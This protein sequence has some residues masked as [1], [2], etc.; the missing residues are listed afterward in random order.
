[1]RKI[2]FN[3]KKS[4]FLKLYLVFFSLINFS[5]V[6]FE[7]LKSMYAKKNSLN[8]TIESYQFKYISSISSIVNFLEILILS[9]FLIY[10]VITF[11]KKDKLGIRNFIL[12]NFSLSISLFFIN[13]IISF[14]FSTPSGNATQQLIIPFSL[15]V[16]VAIFFVINTLYKKIF[17]DVKT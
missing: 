8:N 7:V 3:A 5:Y 16:L 2:I 10:L 1:M 12:I 13:Y 9:M 14:I 4:V 17:R 6:F 15:T 11:V